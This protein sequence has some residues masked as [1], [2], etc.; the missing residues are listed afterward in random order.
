MANING[1]Y[2]AQAEA[3][4]DFSPLPT[5]EYLAQIV[6]SDLKPTKNN[7]GHYLELTFEV[8]EGE[9]KG[10]KHWERLNLDNQNTQT[11]EIANR[12]FAAIREATGVPNPRDSADLHYKPL[13]IR[14]DSFPAGSAR[15]N[16]QVRDRAES[17]VKAYKKAEGA[18]ASGNAPTGSTAA[19]TPAS[20]SSAA[21]PWN[22]RA[23]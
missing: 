12:A 1:L 11:V 8:M 6:D 16:G 23:A 9:Y 4:Q 13:V 5:G 19:A 22:K 14:I 3:Q 10:R 21:A 2:D 20:P 7:T 18:S 17:E 15:R